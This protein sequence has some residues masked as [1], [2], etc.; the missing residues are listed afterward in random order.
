M[1]NLNKYIL[2][3]SGLDTSLGRL[4]DNFATN[5]NSFVND[6][7]TGEANLYMA[8]PENYSEIIS[9]PEDLIATEDSTVPHYRLLKIEI[10]YFRGIRESKTLDLSNKVSI[11][12]GPNSSGKTTFTEAIEW[13]F[14]GQLARYKAHSTGQAT[15]LK[16]CVRHALT[17]GEEET[18]VVLHIQV[19]DDEYKLKR[20]LENDYDGTQHSECSSKLYQND[21]EVQQ[22]NS[23]LAQI[24]LQQ[25]P[26][27]MQHS[28][29][30]FIRSTQD[31]RA[32]YFESLFNIEELSEL[33]RIS[34]ISDDALSGLLHVQT[35]NRFFNAIKGQELLSDS[36]TKT[37]LNI[38]T[39]SNIT[40]ERVQSAIISDLQKL[41]LF[42][43][44][45]TQ[46]KDWKD[47]LEEIK[48]IYK[49]SVLQK[50]PSE[51]TIAPRKDISLINEIGAEDFLEIEQKQSEIQKLTEDHEKIKESL[52]TIDEKSRVVYDVLKTLKE[53]QV[54]NAEVEI[55]D[56]PLC[57][58]T[59]TLTK[60]RIDGI[61][62]TAPIQDA[63][64]Q[65]INN[66]NT[67]LSAIYGRLSSFQ[68]E[69]LSLLP[70]LDDVAKNAEQVSEDSEIN[71]HIEIINPLLE[72]CWIELKTLSNL[73]KELDEK[74]KSQS[75]TFDTVI[76]SEIFKIVAQV[77]V[78]IQKSYKSI[79]GYHSK[80]KDL[81]EYLE[82]SATSNEELQWA[83]VLIELSENASGVLVD[84]QWFFAKNKIATLLECIRKD[85]LIPFRQKIFES[86]ETVLNAGIKSTWAI[87]RR[88]DHA[89][90]IYDCIKLPLPSGK[91]LKPKIEVRAK[92]RDRENDKIMPAL[93]V[94]TESQIN[95]LGMAAFLTKCN[96][97]Q[98][99]I[100]VMDDPL[101]SMD[102]NH[103]EIF[104]EVFMKDILDG[105]KQ[106]ILPTHSQAVSDKIKL[107]Y[108][109]DSNI[110]EYEC[111][112]LRPNGTSYALSDNYIANVLQ[113]IEALISDGS[114]S[115]LKSACSKMRGEVL[116]PF[117]KYLCYKY[118][119][120]SEK[121]LK[122]ATIESMMNEQNG[123]SDYFADYFPQQLDTLRN[124]QDFLNSSCDAHDS[125]DRTQEHVQRKFDEL[126]AAIDAIKAGLTA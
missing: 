28:I 115:Q 33:I 76:I 61:E 124:L 122:K 45:E 68:Q 63:L 5:P 108:Q 86:K 117:Y 49:K 73:N 12:Y 107:K 65:I 104:A 72:I 11:I 20:I 29:G 26:V 89:P 6:W 67:M 27:L 101:Q 21:V 87:F 62:Q 109:F 126:K 110:T 94:F 85:Q 80:F 54:I 1:P 31:K 60:A 51:A 111:S 7:I 71:K 48:G 120:K 119:G 43:S 69:L 59:G 77:P 38:K 123:L 36:E 57:L 42:A 114:Q 102:D 15:E 75:Q 90:T 47:L 113:K 74:I 92:I 78:Q 17:P 32:S 8:D 37:L 79:K 22:S 98:Q 84:I 3:L 93:S 14:T 64:K 103:L 105:D 66:K 9:I 55:Q 24:I 88:D 40:L 53:K 34:I 91:G 116:E 83:R 70:Q 13:L 39:F 18:Y 125:T 121:A 23:I 19:G 41:P 25:P 82:N 56:C 52:K 44:I 10:N 95:L 2:A 118:R 100:Y 99:A 96:I 35:N 46:D 97:E 4:V 30:D 106:L 16:D 50:L 112:C 81:K 58:S